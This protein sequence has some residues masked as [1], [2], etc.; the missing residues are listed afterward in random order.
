MLCWRLDGSPVQ[1]RMMKQR[2]VCAFHRVTLIQVS[3]V[4]HLK[5]FNLGTDEHEQRI[6]GRGRNQSLTPQTG[7]AK[8]SALDARRER[9]CVPRPYRSV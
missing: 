3:E 1:V 2:R 4:F 6:G 7:R 8:C 5:Y 9:V